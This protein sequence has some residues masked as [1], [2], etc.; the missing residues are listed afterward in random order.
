MGSST[1][2]LVADPRFYQLNI[3]HDFENGTCKCP[4][5]AV[6]ETAEINGIIYTAVDNTS[7]LRDRNCEF[8]YFFSN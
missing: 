7:L 5:A 3:S 2:P 4:N 1:I 8:V 6:G